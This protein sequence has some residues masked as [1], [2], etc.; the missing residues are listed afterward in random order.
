M[1]QRASGYERRERDLYETPEWVTE[2]LLPHLPL[3]RL[4][5]IWEP[6]CASGQ[7][8]AALMPTGILIIE[9]DIEPLE[10]GERADFLTCE[11]VQ[12]CDAIITNPPYDKAKE[13]IQHAL[14]V[15][16]R[17][18]GLVAMLL[19]TDYD[20]AKTRAH[21]FDAPPFAKKVVLRKR[22]KW[23]DGGSSPSFNH[24]WFIWDH[25]HRGPATIGYAP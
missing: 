14:Q 11:P 15:T 1:S 8:S 16:Y 22:I 5:L 19:R 25:Q 10:C 3:D 24:A 12:D 13:F 23:F 21:L 7:M 20:H 18:G 6:A 17:T 4:G 9:S 2:A